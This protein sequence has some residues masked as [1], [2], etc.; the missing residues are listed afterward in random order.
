MLEFPTVFAS[1]HWDHVRVYFRFYAFFRRT[2]LFHDVTLGYCGTLK[3]N[4]RGGPF[5]HSR[6]MDNR[7]KHDPKESLSY[8]ITFSHN[9]HFAKIM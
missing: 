8:G 1:F 3:I 4:A 6:K 9:T 7:R 5:S 2:L